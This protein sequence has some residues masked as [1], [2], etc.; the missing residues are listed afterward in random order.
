MLL[1]QSAAAAQVHTCDNAG[2]DSDQQHVDHMMDHSQTDHGMIHEVPV[3]RDYCF[4]L[5]NWALHPGT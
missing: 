1:L 2:G 4:M 3:D 5:H